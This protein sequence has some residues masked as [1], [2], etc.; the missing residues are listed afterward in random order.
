M[1]YIKSYI[2]TSVVQADLGL[3]VLTQ[4]TT[5][6]LTPSPT[7]DCFALTEQDESL[8]IA[9]P[10]PAYGNF[11]IFTV[12]IKDNGTARAL[13][14]GNK[15]RAQGSALPTTTTIS[16]VMNLVFMYDS[17]ADKYDVK[18]SEEV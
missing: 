12:R 1:D 2:Y 7:Y 4:E 15:Y 8:T 17:T 3:I 18:W 6:T 10:S 13:T 16:K 5:A 14:F 9:N 11:E